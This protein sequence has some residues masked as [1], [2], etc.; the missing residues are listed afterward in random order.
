MAMIHCPKC[1]EKYSDTYRE[2]PFCEEEEALLDG[3]EIRRSE[4]VRKAYLGG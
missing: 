4:M 2:C 1:G 3:E